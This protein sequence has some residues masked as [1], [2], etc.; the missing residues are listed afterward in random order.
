LPPNPQELLGR[1]EFSRLLNELSSVYDVILV[2]TPSAQQSSD[3]HVVALRAGSA[4]IVGRK[5]RT[6][7]TEI[8]QLASIM[9]NS[10]IRI[11]GTTLNEP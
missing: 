11:L 6:R 9:Q 1:P 5:D 2:D 4:L 7:A 3:A 10:G 8:A